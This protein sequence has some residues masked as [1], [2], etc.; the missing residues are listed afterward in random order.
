[1]SNS[2]PGLTDFTQMNSTDADSLLKNESDFQR[3]LNEE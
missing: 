2:I 3:F 1:M